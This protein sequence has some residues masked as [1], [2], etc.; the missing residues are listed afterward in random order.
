MFMNDEK[1]STDQQVFD[2]PQATAED[3]RLAKSASRSENWQRWGT[4]LPE[5]Q[6]GT[7][8]ED[9]SAEGNA[10]A[11]THDMARY[12]AYRW[13]EDGILGWT[14]REC[15]LCF[16][17]SL[18]NGNDPILKERLFGLGNPEG[19]HGEDVKEQYYYLDATPTHSYCKALYKYTI[20]QSMSFWTQPS[21][22]RSVTSMYRWSMPKPVL[23]TP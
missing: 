7:V 4:Y 22:M 12:R 13:G 20:S 5:R 8:R 14:D 1:T 6:W 19:N 21:S 18:W 11:F 15:R 3:D 17:I 2:R 9:Y 23:K 16:A 10:W